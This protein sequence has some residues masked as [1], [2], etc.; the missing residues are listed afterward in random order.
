MSEKPRQREDT[1]PDHAHEYTL[2]HGKKKWL[3]KLREEAFERLGFT[4]EEI[5]E[6]LKAK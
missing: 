6:L 3:R 5:A 4:P 1:A 2:A